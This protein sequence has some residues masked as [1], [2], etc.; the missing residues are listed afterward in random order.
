LAKPKSH[1]FLRGGA[2]VPNQGAQENYQYPNVRL[3]PMFNSNRLKNLLS[4]T[5]N[6]SIE[7]KN[8]SVIK[9]QEFKGERLSPSQLINQEFFEQKRQK[10]EGRED[11]STS[12]I[13][14]GLTMIGSAAITAGLVIPGLSDCRRR[15]TVAAGSLL[16]CAAIF[17]PFSLTFAQSQTIKNVGESAKN[18]KS[19]SETVNLIFSKVNASADKILDNFVEVSPEQRNA[20]IKGLLDLLMATEI[21]NCPR[22][23]VGVLQQ[24][25][26]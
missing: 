16:V 3:Q 23:R 20:V 14:K 6:T 18:A 5:V 9:V 19:A 25:V 26:L 12:Q 11:P 24:P 17:L 7:K 2:D 15:T 13:I 10:E 21:A 4:K 8:Y 22:E 1:P